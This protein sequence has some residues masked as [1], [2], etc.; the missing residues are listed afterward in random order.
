M[1]KGE[2]HKKTGSGVVREEAVREYGPRRLS[3]KRH[4]ATVQVIE[5]IS[6]GLPFSEIEH[7]RAEIDEP[8]ESLAHQLSI[9]RSTLQRRRAERRLSPQESDRVMR[10]WK[11]IRQAVKLFG[12]IDRARAWLKHPQFGLGGAVPLDF[13]KTEIGARE[14]EDLLGRIE[15]SVYS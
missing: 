7:L 6:K 9:S 14:V 1:G 13:A 11:L 15:F 5:Q 3:S 12:S 4:V 8:L 10:F 2:K